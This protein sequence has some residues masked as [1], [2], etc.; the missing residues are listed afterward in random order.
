MFTKANGK[1]S[2]R[3]YGRKKS[4]RTKNKQNHH[5]YFNGR[6]SSE[7]ALTGRA[8]EYDQHTHRPTDHATPS[9]GTGRYC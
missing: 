2:Y 4:Q 7:L 5:L 6:F 8:H 9:V 1:L 3:I